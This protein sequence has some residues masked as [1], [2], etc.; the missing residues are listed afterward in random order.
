MTYFLNRLLLILSGP[1]T[2]NQSLRI[3]R[4]SHRLIRFV[5]A[6]PLLKHV[7]GKKVE[8]LKIGRS[9]LQRGVS[10]LEKKEKLGTICSGGERH[11]F[12]PVYNFVGGYHA[13][14]VTFDPFDTVTEAPKQRLL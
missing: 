9:Y 4:R 6:L 8:E 7:E 3:L 10:F 14:V 2:G 11:I 5:S 12:L 13:L 1:D